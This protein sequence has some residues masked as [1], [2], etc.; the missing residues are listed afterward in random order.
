MLFD[1]YAKDLEKWGADV[2]K[3][4][5]R[6]AK[7]GA[8]KFVKEAQDLTDK[9]GL[10]DTGAYKGHWAAKEIELEDGTEA[11][12]CSNSM[13]YSNAL[14]LGHKTRNGGWWKGRF[15]GRRAIDEAVYYCIEELDKE[16]EKAV[17]TTLKGK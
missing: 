8:V 5:K 2:P 6:V 4:F 13:D 11:V 9:E 14:E 16:F 10:V 15:V 7:K 3:V 17:K 12:L 1:K